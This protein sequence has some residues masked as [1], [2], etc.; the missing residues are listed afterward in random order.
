[1]KL[2]KVVLWVCLLS[3]LACSQDDREPEF[4]ILGYWNLSKV[5]NAMMVNASETPSFQERYIFNDD[6]TFIKFSTRIGTDI[7]RGELPF[8][9]FGKYALI[10]SAEASLQ[11]LFEVE[12]IYETNP[13]IAGSC[14]PEIELL[15][16][17]NSKQLKNLSWSACDG[18]IL[19][20]TRR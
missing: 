11:N 1:M 4:S 2:T 15:H 9:S 18:P 19:V 12:L 6:G 16:F 10:N 17:D 14:L 7:E 13:Q 8:Q 3:C 5:Q 20:Y